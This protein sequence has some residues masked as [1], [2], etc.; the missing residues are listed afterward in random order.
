MERTSIKDRLAAGKEKKAENA[1]KEKSNKA[2]ARQEH[3]L[4]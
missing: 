3:A 4:A 2:K 1:I